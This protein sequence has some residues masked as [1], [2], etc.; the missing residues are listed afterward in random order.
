MV[1]LLVEKADRD[2]LPDLSEGLV[3]GGGLKHIGQWGCTSSTLGEAG[4]SV[5]CSSHFAGELETSMDGAKLS[6]WLATS[7]MEDT[8]P[9]EADEVAPQPLRYTL[10]ATAPRVTPYPL[11]GSYPNCSGGLVA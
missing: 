11:G 5:Q 3:G 6:G 2:R 8:I 9:E 10:S 1:S 4:H 7:M